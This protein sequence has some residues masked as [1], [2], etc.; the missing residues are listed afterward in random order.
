MTVAII[1]NTANGTTRTA[2]LN[3]R[4]GPNTDALIALPDSESQTGQP[5][6]MSHKKIKAISKEALMMLYRHFL[7]YHSTGSS[8][9][10]IGGY[11]GGLV[12]STAPSLSSSALMD[13]RK[14]SATA[15]R[16]ILSASGHALLMA[17]TR[18]L[19]GSI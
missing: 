14:F 15:C 9:Y 7:K 4:F 11:S 2:M 19:A 10:V 1:A 5:F 12:F 18:R 8:G 6:A 17:T 16:F 13:R 3:Q